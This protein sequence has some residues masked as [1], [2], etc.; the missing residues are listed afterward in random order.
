M[1]RGHIKYYCYIWSQI[2]LKTTAIG[3]SLLG[4]LF[5]ASKSSTS[6][7]WFKPLSWVI[8]QVS[9]YGLLIFLILGG[10]SVAGFSLGSFGRDKWV[11][12]SILHL[13]NGYRNK[14]FSN[15]GTDPI[16]N[17]RVTI[18]RHKRVLCFIEWVKTF[19]KH[20]LYGHWLVA[21]YRTGHTT[22]DSEIKFR[23]PVKRPLEA[24]GVAGQAWRGKTV[25]VQDLLLISTVSGKNNKRRYAESSHISELLVEQ[26]LKCGGQ[27]P[28]SMVGVPLKVGQKMWGSLVIDSVEPKGTCLEHVANYTLFIQ[29]LGRLLEKL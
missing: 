5:A 13:L 17:H 9:E 14:V 10:L 20:P 3:S 23:A 26:I 25:E 2:L 28:R 29:S 22:Q 27:L 19:G 4:L 6:Y 12:D 24:E 16:D 11:E 8:T 7:T 15:Y 1:A 18:F 21:E